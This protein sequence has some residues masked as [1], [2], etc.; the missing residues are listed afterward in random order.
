MSHTP[1]DDDRIASRAELLPE[2]TEAGSDDPT[3]QAEA[4]LAESDERVDDPEGTRRESTQTPDR[5][6]P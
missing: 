1:E 5:S 3:A 4:I 2:E 6:D